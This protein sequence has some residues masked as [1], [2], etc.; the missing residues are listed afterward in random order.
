[1]KV[2][3]SLMALAMVLAMAMSTV[4]AFASD[5]PGG[6]IMAPGAGTTPVELTADA[7]TFSV[8]VPTSIPIKVNADG[9]VTCPTDGTVKIVNNSAG[10]VKVIQ[11]EMRNGAWTLADYKVGDRTLVAAAG[12]DAKKLGMQLTAGSQVLAT[13]TDGD[14]VISNGQDISNWKMTGV[15][16]DPATTDELPINVAAIASAVSAKIETAEQAASVIFTIAW[17]AV[18][19]G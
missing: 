12:V 13:S 1:M 11:V 15:V 2:R 3:K 19:A 17:D 5:V 18:S 6:P 10:A 8:T 9:T 16:T 4:P 7:T 14:Q